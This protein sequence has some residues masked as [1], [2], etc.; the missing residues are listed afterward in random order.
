ME[1]TNMTIGRKFTLT[2]VIVTVVVLI[3]G[4]LV[5]TKYKNDLRDEIYNDV[6]VNMNSLSELRIG[7][8]LDV[9]ISN[10]TSIANDSN[11]QEALS[12]NDRQ[13]AIKTI[14]SLSS[15]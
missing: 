10:A 13:L 6:I 1:I 15:T 9:G 3:I 7:S 4:F 11:I 5:L 8:K 2:N 12:S 14:S